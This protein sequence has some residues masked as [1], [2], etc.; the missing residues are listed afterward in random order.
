MNRLENGLYIFPTF[1]HCQFVDL[2]FPGFQK[3][4]DWIYRNGLNGKN[5]IE[6][7]LGISQ[8]TEKWTIL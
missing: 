3:A 4:W 6:I 5:V 2:D 8:E 7:T 1:L